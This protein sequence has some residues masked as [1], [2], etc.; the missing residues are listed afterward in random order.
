[1]KK[2]ILLICVLCASLSSFGYAQK[3]KSAAPKRGA[4]PP[5]EQKDFQ[6]NKKGMPRPDGPMP[7]RGMD[8]GPG[9]P[10]PPPPL[11]P[12]CP[13]SKPKPG[14]PPGPGMG[15]PPGERPPM[16]GRPKPPAPKKGKAAEGK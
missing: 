11:P 2:R 15:M 5:T 10:P 6:D 16:K 7:R 12:G 4:K 14:R 1:M 9:M 3:A 8:R 13:C